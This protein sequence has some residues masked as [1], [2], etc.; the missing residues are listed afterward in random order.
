[1]D[2]AHAV[3]MRQRHWIVVI[4]LVGL[5][6][7]G[8]FQFP[9]EPVI[10]EPG[11][12]APPSEDVPD[13]GPPTA[14]PEGGDGAGGTCVVVHQR[15]GCG[16][17]D[18]RLVFDA[19]GRLI[20]REQEGCGSSD[21]TTWIIG[22]QGGRLVSYDLERVPDGQAPVQVERELTWDA[23][24]RLVR[25]RRDRLDF[26]DIEDG[27]VALTWGESGEIA[28]LELDIFVGVQWLKWEAEP[29]Y[30][31]GRMTEIRWHE[32]GHPVAAMHF[33]YPPGAGP[34]R[35]AEGPSDPW[36]QRYCDDW[37]LPSFVGWD[38][39][40]DGF[41]EYTMTH[42]F[43]DSGA[44][45]ERVLDVSTAIQTEEFDA[46]EVL[47][48]RLVDQGGDGTVDAVLKVVSDAQ[49]FPIE[50]TQEDGA[51]ATTGG[52]LYTVERSGA[53]SGHETDPVSLFRARAYHPLWSPSGGFWLAP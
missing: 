39:Y 31:D 18:V 23:A 42:S 7:A 36:D 6:A 47:V 24:G 50:V 34:S 48:R 53:C 29:A 44:L 5:G 30:E 45:R 14:P 17:F 41:Y 8:C 28:G 13:E 26:D 37:P 40:A 10:P 9:G 11:G 16:T 1:M 38:A 32:G 49:G 25:F 19:D 43:H 33:D 4:G 22:W 3:G 46:S 20:T 12:A 51:G 15:V 35:C 27:E 2:L 21:P 52:A